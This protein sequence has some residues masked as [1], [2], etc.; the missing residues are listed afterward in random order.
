VDSISFDDLPDLSVFGNRGEPFRPLCIEDRH[1]EIRNR[2]KPSIPATPNATP[3][4]IKMYFAGDERT[5]A[6]AFFA[7]TMT[8]GEATSLLCC[9]GHPA[10]PEHSAEAE[11]VSDLPCLKPKRVWR[12]RFALRELVQGISF[13]LVLQE[14]PHG[15][16]LHEF[17]R[18]AFHFLSALAFRLLR[19]CLMHRC[20]IS[21]KFSP[22]CSLLFVWP[23]G[24]P[25]I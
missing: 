15:T 22:G 24:R 2:L 4:L 6:A 23:R 13:R 20:E 10:V 17:R 21:S 11:K 25:L 9:A 18:S 5:R 14:L 1:S 7:S 16:N 3:L 19:A 8:P 12:I